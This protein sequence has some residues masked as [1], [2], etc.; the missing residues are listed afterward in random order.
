MNLIKYSDLDRI[1]KVRVK[2]SKRRRHISFSLLNNSCDLECLLDYLLNEVKSNVDQGIGWLF[3]CNISKSY[4]FHRI[5]RTL[6]KD[7]VDKDNQCHLSFH[8]ISNVLIMSRRLLLN[9]KFKSIIS[10][11]YEH[12]KTFIYSVNIFDMNLRFK[13]IVDSISHKENCILEFK[14]SRTLD[15]MSSISKYN[16]DMQMYMYMRFTN[17]SKYKFIFVNKLAPHKIHI[18]ED[19]ETISYIYK[20]GE[21]KYNSYISRFIKIISDNNLQSVFH[22]E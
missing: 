6:D 21:I 8:T 14:T 5:L 19:S 12:E 1:S 17:M 2:Y 9:K 15:L 20:M 16:Y 4:A 3:H 22:H 13:I 10:L 18:I 11:S 7:Y